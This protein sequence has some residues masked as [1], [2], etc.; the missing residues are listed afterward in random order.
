MQARCVAIAVKRTL[1]E[2]RS[3]DI[4]IFKKNQ[5]KIL[6]NVAKNASPFTVDDKVQVLAIKCL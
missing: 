4:D 5:I 2:R 1:R 3:E 6:Q